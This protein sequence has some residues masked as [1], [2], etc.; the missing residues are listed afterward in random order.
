MIYSDAFSTEMSPNFGYNVNNLQ[1]M[2]LNIPIEIPEN[3]YNYYIE[4]IEGNTLISLFTVKSTAKWSLDIISVI[5]GL[6]PAG[7]R[8]KNPHLP[9]SGL[10]L[11]KAS[12]LAYSM[13]H[14]I[15]SYQS[16]KV[17]GWIHVFIY[18]ILFFFIFLVATETVSRYWVALLQWYSDI[19]FESLIQFCLSFFKKLI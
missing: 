14:M 4:N 7:I 1:F 6:Y 2:L 5:V 16:H 12:H 17:L 9:S 11:Y 19:N 8:W 15:Q 13:N 3:F 18:F 10:H